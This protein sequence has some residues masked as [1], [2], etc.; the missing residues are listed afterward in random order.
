[1]IILD[2]KSISKIFGKGD[3]LG[4]TDAVM[5]ECLKDAGKVE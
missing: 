1:M 3:E 2:S 5:Q 4:Q